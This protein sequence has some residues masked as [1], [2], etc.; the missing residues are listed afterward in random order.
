MRRQDGQATVEWLAVVLLVAL[1][2]AGALA[3][4]PGTGGRD[5][6]R[7]IAR[8]IGCAARG[9]CEEE[10]RAATPLVAAALPRAAAAP[11]RSPATAR[12][13]PGAR[14]AG[15]RGAPPPI[16]PRPRFRF[17]FRLPPERVAQAYRLLRGA[18]AIARRAW[19]ACLGWERLQ[20][21]RRHPEASIP[22]HRMP[23]ADAVR[24]AEACLNP[25]GFITE[26][27]PP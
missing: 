16:V 17:R 1:A 14:F 23:L 10:A 24:I 26:E 21:E 12:R 6:G 2:L 25:V 18:K 3:L 4:V 7:A 5:L 15:S 27:R 11:R 13:A 8:S 22:G 20:W 19:V 9:G